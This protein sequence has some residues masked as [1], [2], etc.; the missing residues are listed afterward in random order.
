M[1]VILF[2]LRLGLRQSLVLG[3]GGV[4]IQ[5][6]SSANNGN[7]LLTMEY[8]KKTGNLIDKYFNLS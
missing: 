4:K 7:S 1:A 6:M 8:H 3:G 2:I 5:M